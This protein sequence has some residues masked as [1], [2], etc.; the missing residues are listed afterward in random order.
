MK[1]IIFMM[2]PVATLAAQFSPTPFPVFLKSGFSS[3]LE[4]DEAPIRVVLGDGQSFQVEKVDRSVVIRTLTPYAASNMFV[5]FKVSVPR[6]FILTASED[7]NPTYYKKFD[8]EIQPKPSPSQASLKPAAIKS[9]P[10]GIFEVKIIKADFDAKKDYLNLECE[11]HSSSKEL[12]KPN[13]KLARLSF[14][15]NVIKP[16]KLWA[17]REAVQKD[18]EVRFRLIF[19]KP[20][21]PRDLVGVHLIIPLLGSQVPIITLLKGRSL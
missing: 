13:W 8:K 17:E 9:V 10:N 18:S 6:L 11:L 1:K 3:V 4:F 12:I 19:A 21:L 20:N 14:K 7:A 2:W 15:S 16:F 5:Y